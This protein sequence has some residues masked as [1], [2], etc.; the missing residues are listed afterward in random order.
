MA[1]T[2]SAMQTKITHRF[3]RLLSVLMALDMIENMISP[4][5]WILGEQRSVL[6]TIATLSSSAH[7]LALGKLRK[8]GGLTPDEVDYLLEATWSIRNT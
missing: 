4:A 8:G 2:T 7:A 6:A 3:I 5:L 1:S